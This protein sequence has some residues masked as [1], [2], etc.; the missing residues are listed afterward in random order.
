MQI[1]QVFFL[2]DLARSC[3]KSCTCLASL[4]LKMKLFLQDIYTLARILQENSKI[5]F[6]QDLITIL[7]ENYLANVSCTILARFLYLTRKASFL[8]QDLQNLVQDFASLAR[9]VLERFG[10]FLQDSF[11]GIGPLWVHVHVI[12]TLNATICVCFLLCLSFFHHPPHP[13]APP[14]HSLYTLAQY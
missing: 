14:A 5:R 7:Q 8:A 1:L 2:Q 4:A 13:C 6:L 3:I 9:K 11:T 12:A 10:Y